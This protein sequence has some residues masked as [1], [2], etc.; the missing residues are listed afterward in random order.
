MIKPRQQAPELEINLVNGTTWK[1]SVQESKNFTM[2]VF[3]RGK[4]CSVCKTYLEEL[5]TKLTGFSELGVHVVAISADMEAVAKETY[6][7]WDIKDLPLG[8]E[9][10]VEEANAWGLFVSAGGKNE[11]EKYIEP[12]LFL[13]KPDN[14]VFYAA[15]QSMPFGRPEFDNVL[16]GIKYALK[17]G[18]E[19]HG[20]L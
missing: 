7:A 13:I 18:G 6:A 2:I 1:L 9:F 12:G 16:G 3:Y 17:K 8:Y 15:I 14:T 5:Q 11:P 19:A 4:H 20:E 10:P